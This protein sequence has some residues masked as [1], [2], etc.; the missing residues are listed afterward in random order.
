V[1]QPSTTDSISL[2]QNYLQLPDH[3]QPRLRRLLT[4][5]PL[6]WSE[7]ADLGHASPMG[8]RLIGAWP[9]IRTPNSFLGVR[10]FIGGRLLLDA[11]AVA[12]QADGTAILDDLLRRNPPIRHLARHLAQ[13]LLDAPEPVQ[14]WPTLAGDLAQL[15][16]IPSG[17]L[18]L[19]ADGQLEDVA[20]M[21]LQVQA[22]EH[23]PTLSWAAWGWA[24]SSWS[25]GWSA[26]PDH[27]SAISR[28]AW[29]ILALQHQEPEELEAGPPQLG[30]V[31]NPRQRPEPTWITPPRRYVRTAD[32]P[33][34]SSGS[35]VRP[36]W[37]QAHQHRFWTGKGR[38]T[39]IA[40]W[41]PA[42]WID[43]QQDQGTA[44]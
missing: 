22:G 44:A 37:R 11:W 30:I 32:L 4:D 27:T 36:H 29:S 39:L 31:R 20:V 26:R 9:D 2:L 19:P 1:N 23:G 24:G 21:G 8:Q 15:V 35:H 17:L 25:D 5:R 7:L 18:Q 28:L 40:R 10:Q 14:P 13:Q 33:A 41:I 34:I 43:G 3:Q 6:R 16:L 42:L 38:N 12:K